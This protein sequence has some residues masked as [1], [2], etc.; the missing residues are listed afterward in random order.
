MQRKLDRID[1]QAAR[2]GQAVKTFRDNY[3]RRRYAAAEAIEDEPSPEAK[4]KR[5]LKALFNTSMGR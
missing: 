4:T 1:R 3:G 5:V 2:E